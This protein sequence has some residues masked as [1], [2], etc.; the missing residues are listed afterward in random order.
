MGFRFVMWSYHIIGRIHASTGSMQHWQLQHA[1]LTASSATSTGSIC[2]T[3]AQSYLFA[4]G[5]IDRTHS[6]HIRDHFYKMDPANNTQD[7]HMRLEKNGVELRPMVRCAK[8]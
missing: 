1:A 7:P 5:E 4:R 8:F 2:W 3:R 6:R